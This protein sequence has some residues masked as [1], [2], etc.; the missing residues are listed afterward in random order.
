M[1][2]VQ[3]VAK[4]SEPET[5]SWAS[6]VVNYA[7]AL[8]GSSA[9]AIKE[10]D[11]RDIDLALLNKISDGDKYLKELQNRRSKIQS[12]IDKITQ[13]CDV[14]RARYNSNN[15]L[16]DRKLADIK[17]Q[18]DQFVCSVSQAVGPSTTAHEEWSRS[19]TENKPDPNLVTLKQITKVLDFSKKLQFQLGKDNLFDHV[20]TV[21]EQVTVGY[22]QAKALNMKIL[23]AAAECEDRK[24]PLLKQII[25]IDHKIMQINQK[26]A[27]IKQFKTDYTK[28][29]TDS[30]GPIVSGAPIRLIDSKNM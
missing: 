10:W 7:S 16:I 4:T 22:H 26:M 23:D 13:E 3:Q 2:S 9:T 1:D 5:V 28:I 6:S 12:E 14:I 20:S 19:D 11:T 21:G 18:L 24:Q 8:F 17:A 29:T 25:Q 30:Q 15:E 27:L